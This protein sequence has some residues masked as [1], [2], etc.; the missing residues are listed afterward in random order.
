M[1]MPITILITAAQI[2]PFR[3]PSKANGTTVMRPTI[4]LKNTRGRGVARDKRWARPVA[5][6]A[7]MAAVRA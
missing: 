7:R 4:Q 6:S 1:Q 3:L 2:F 5:A